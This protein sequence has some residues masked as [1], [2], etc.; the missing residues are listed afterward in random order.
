M[1][2]NDRIRQQERVAQL[3]AAALMA[4]VPILGGVAYFLVRSGLWEPM[5]QAV[6][7]I[8]PYAG[9]AVMAVGLLAAPMLGVRLRDALAALPEDETVR[10]Y[11]AS[12]V[13]PQAVREGVG[14]VGVMAGMLAGSPTWIL[15]FAAASVGSQAM[16][17]PRSG[18]LQARLERR[19]GLEG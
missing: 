11:A 17:F 2:R 8:V 19:A 13:V 3:V 5:D 1:D 6:G 16:A 15:I 7:R 12:I 14:L 4:G 18:D 10:R 9:V